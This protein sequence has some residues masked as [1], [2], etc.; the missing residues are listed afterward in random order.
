M[1]SAFS[2]RKKIPKNEKHFNKFVYLISLIFFLSV[3]LTPRIYSYIEFFEN[4]L[5]LSKIRDNTDEYLNLGTLKDLKVKNIEG[6]ICFIPK[7]C[8]KNSNYNL[9]DYS[10]IY[11][12]KLYK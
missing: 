1:I 4:P 5:T 7:T 11:Q 2:I 3:G 9:L 10:V 12:Y 8:V 6:S